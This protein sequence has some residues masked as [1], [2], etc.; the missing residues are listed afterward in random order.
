MFLPSIM[1]CEYVPK[2][3]IYIFIYIFIN[4]SIAK[5]SS[6]DSSGSKMFKILFLSSRKPG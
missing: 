4:F 2:I 5:F 6:W 1:Y 3:N